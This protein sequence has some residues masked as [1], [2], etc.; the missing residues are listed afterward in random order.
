MR[1]LLEPPGGIKAQLGDIA[2]AGQLLARA[3]TEAIGP[4][5]CALR[6]HVDEVERFTK[7]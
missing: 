3:S 1:A 6:G 4:R 7:S 2:C 5:R